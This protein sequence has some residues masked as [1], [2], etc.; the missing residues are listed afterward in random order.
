MF[1]VETSGT[2]WPNLQRSTLDD[3]PIKR[4]WVCVS[5]K[6]GFRE[7][8]IDLADEVKVIVPGLGDVLPGWKPTGEKDPK[9]GYD[10]VAADPNY[11]WPD[12]NDALRWASNGK[13]VFLQPRNAKFDI[14]KNNLM[15][16]QDIIRDHPELRLSVQLHK[17]LRVQ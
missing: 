16:V 5:P 1:H 8:M 6:P 13:V 7:D 10:I 4:M 14:D 11:R 9:S 17:V 12:I 3:Y 15:I 2:V